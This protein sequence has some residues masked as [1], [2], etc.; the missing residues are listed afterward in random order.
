MTKKKL[1][2]YVVTALLTTNLLYAQS[3]SGIDYYRLGD[4]LRA[5]EYLTKNLSA[6]P[7]Q[8]NY[9]L[10]EIAF[11]EKNPTLAAEFYNK[12]LSTDPANL[13]NQIGLLK[14]KLKSDR[15]ATEKELTA[16]SKKAKKDVDAQIAIA[17]AFLDNEM[18]E[19]AKKQFEAAR[20]AGSKNPS[21]YILEGDILMTEG[22]DPKK[23]G[24]AAAK[25]DQAIYFDPNFPLGYMKSALVYE[26][27][28]STDAI[29]KL[30]T[31][32]E[33][34]PDYLPAYGLIGKI[35]TSNG[36]YPQAIEAFKKLGESNMQVDD[37][38]RYARAEFFIEPE[39]K[40]PK[41]KDY[42]AAKK[43]V[44]NGLKMNPDHFVL[45]RYL[46]YIDSRTNQTEEGLALADKFFKFRVDSGYISEDFVAHANLLVQAKRFEEAYV[47]F[48]K[49]IKLTPT[50]FKLYDDAS[51]A[52][53]EE[54]NYIKQAS[55]IQQKIDAKRKESSDSNYK[56]DLIDITTLGSS[57]YLAGAAIPKNLALAEK[58][59]QN[60]AIVESVKTK[61]PSVVADSLSD[62]SYF[63][64][65]YGKYYLLKA[66]SIFD[67]QIAMAPESYTGYRYKA[68]INNLLNPLISNDNP[69]LIVG[70]AKPH[71]EKV[72]EILTKPD[73]KLTTATTRI[74]VEAYGY[75]GLYYYYKDDKENTLTYWKKVLELDPENA[76][77]KAV[78]EDVNKRL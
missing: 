43:I 3:N 78:I 31:V 35:Y 22:S 49:V 44:E 18:T 17:R 37:M 40:D 66:D 15:Q 69:E 5:K 42:T 68:V 13:L 67:V 59:L 65:Y 10:G 30:K 26:K 72:I 19:Q 77:A 1:I 8:N 21:V 12:G 76:T 9:Y 46:L 75:L 7:A 27:I 55:Y 33:S 23:L 53:G 32:I 20:K 4:L 38:E 6:N 62:V 63:A 60:P 16:I 41:D 11:A 64:K 2:V 73:N 24:D 52:A 14:L 61:V 34:H 28:N 57:Y 70:A 51:S 39:S 29:S 74:L 56:D 36:F 54:K 48:D 58:A 25:Y 71:Y 45:N 47:A 50:E